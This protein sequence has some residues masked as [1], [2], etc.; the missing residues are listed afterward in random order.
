MKITSAIM[1]IVMAVTLSSCAK[2]NPICS[3]IVEKEIENRG[4]RFEFDLANGV[5][6]SVS[7]NTFNTFNVGQQ[8]CY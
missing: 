5:E 6:L 7:R 2:R 1:A 8:Y 4:S 3:N